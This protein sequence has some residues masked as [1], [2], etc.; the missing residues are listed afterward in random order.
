[1]IKLF[2][3]VYLLVNFATFFSILF[4]LPFH[5][6]LRIAFFFS[7]VLP[8]SLREKVKI[9]LIYGDNYKSVSETAAILNE[10]YP[11]KPV[12]YLLFLSRL[13]EKFKE[14]NSEE[15]QNKIPVSDW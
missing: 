7:R 13:M 5:I 1:M 12:H 11:N 10:R 8:L 2:Q 15:N 6:C 9:I 14:T 4:K 3:L